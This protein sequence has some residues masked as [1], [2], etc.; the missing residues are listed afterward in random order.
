MGILRAF[1][2]EECGAVT[3]DW[4]ALTAGIML[5]GIAT[6]YTVLEEGVSPTVGGINERLDSFDFPNLN[7]PGNE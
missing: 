7:L 5:L 2:E 1:L 3:V 6:V 4:V